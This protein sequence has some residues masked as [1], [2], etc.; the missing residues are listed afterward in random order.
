MW[1]IGGMQEPPSG[2]L[3]LLELSFYGRK[4]KNMDFFSKSDPFIV[5]YV[6]NQVGG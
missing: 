2:T 4:L 3:P 1:K 6:G 5:V